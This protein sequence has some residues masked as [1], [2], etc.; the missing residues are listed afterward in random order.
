MIHTSTKLF[1][2]CWFSKCKMTNVG[3]SL[4]LKYAIKLLL[5]SIHSLMLI[6]S[7][8]QAS[9]FQSNSTP[10]ISTIQNWKKKI[11]KA[12]LENKTT[13]NNWNTLI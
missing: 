1:P 7:Y 5:S 13:C 6:L 3:F 12:V 2:K 10:D 9:K 4:L 11:V 8:Y